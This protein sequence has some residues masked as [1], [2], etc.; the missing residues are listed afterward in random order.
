LAVPVIASVLAAITSIIAAHFGVV[1]STDSFMTDTVTDK[2][3]V[4]SFPLALLEGVTVNASV[5]SAVTVIVPND[6]AIKCAAKEI[7]VLWLSFQRSTVTTVKKKGRNVLA[8]C[9]RCDGSPVDAF[10]LQGSKAHGAL[11]TLE[12]VHK[13]DIACLLQ[14]AR[15]L[16]NG[17][18]LQNGTIDIDGTLHLAESTMLIQERGSRPVQSQP[19]MSLT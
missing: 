18:L 11:L 1:A 4:K 17:V 7:S 8:R 15:L 12:T 2:G 10:R 9:F 13:G 3:R 14:V 19:A 16:Q 5:V 6:A